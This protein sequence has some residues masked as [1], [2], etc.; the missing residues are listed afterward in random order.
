VSAVTAV[1]AC[2]ASPDQSAAFLR[3]L[4]SRGEA[5]SIH[6]VLITLPG[7]PAPPVPEGFL[8]VTQMAVE[9]GRG[10]EHARA[11][12]AAEA[13]TDLV[14]YVEDHVRFHGPWV[15]HAL[16]TLSDGGVAAL[17]WTVLAGDPHDTLRMAGW[18]VEYATWGPGREAGPADHLAGHNCV[19]RREAL[20]EAGPALPSLLRAESVLHWHLAR[21]GR[22]LLFTRDVTIS[23]YSFDSLALQIVTD[24]WYGWNFADA[25][26]A[27]E[28]WTAGTRL[29][30]AA[31]APLVPLVR[32]ARL[33]RTARANGTPPRVLLRCGPIAA[34]TL[35]AGA[36]GETA[37]TLLGERGASARLTLLDTV[38]R[39]LADAG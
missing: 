36:L 25:R 32:A 35:T 5:P 17:G 7:R 20:L 31:G 39:N 34:L 6:L 28:A 2:G 12:A 10:S 11:R 15:D 13:S 27:D 8:S 21:R 22:T 3:H 14:A 24:F 33:L 4:A 16:H 1:V 26:A 9:H 23:H 19:Y 38:E 30:R 29:L 18:L 37:G